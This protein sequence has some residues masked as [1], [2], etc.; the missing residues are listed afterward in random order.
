MDEKVGLDLVHMG[1]D[2]IARA[3]FGVPGFRSCC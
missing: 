3:T 2:L 1:A